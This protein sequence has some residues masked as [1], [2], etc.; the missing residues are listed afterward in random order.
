MTALP[1]RP[2]T[3]RAQALAL[4]AAPLAGLATTMT[5]PHTPLDVAQRLDV[6][7]DSAGRAQLAHA[8]TLLTILLF[9]PAAA[10]MHRLLQP[11]R[12]RAAA[13]G[14]CLVGA[15]L[16]GWTGVL[17]LGIAELQ[18]ARTLVGGEAAPMAEALQQAPMAGALL[19]LF[20]LGLFSG[21][22]VLTV[23]LWRAGVVRGWVPAAVGAAVVADILASTF[24]LVVIGVWSLLAVAF[25]SIAAARAS[26]T[27]SMT[28][29]PAGSGRTVARG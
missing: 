23:G 2:A 13:L 26:T 4:V 28:P 6:L 1:D 5:W 3:R 22:V 10:G 8:L 21:L 15:G 19:A 7:A 25:T 27:P 14:G 18:V 12:P 20:L 24:T 16:V 17:A 9:L 11:V 29:D